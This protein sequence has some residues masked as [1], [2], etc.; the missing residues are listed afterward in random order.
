MT[1][2]V[3]V[4][5][6]CAFIPMI[7]GFI[8]Y[9]P[10]VFGKVWQK[11]I[12]LSDEEMAKP[13]KWYQF[14]LSL[15]LNFLLAFGVFIVTV[16]QSHILSITGPDFEAINT[17]TAAAFMNEYGGNFLTLKHG[18]THGIFIAFLAFALPFIGSPAIWEKKGFK[19]VLVNSGYWVITLTIMACVIS[20][21]GG[22]AVT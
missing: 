11:T 17:G 15:I 16:H 9:N 14:V 20:R 6:A 7:L 19:Y 8:W 22:V 10:N 2:N 4:L 5:I 3:I 12:G 1:P 13:S 18:I 21:W